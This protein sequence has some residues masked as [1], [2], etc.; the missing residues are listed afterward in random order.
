[1]RKNTGAQSRDRISQAGVKE[2]LADMMVFEPGQGRQ[3][4]FQQTR[5]E[6]CTDW[7]MRRPS[8]DFGN[9]RVRCLWGHDR[10]S[11]WKGRQG[12]DQMRN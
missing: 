7:A 10:K 5:K 11:G 2:S 9:I 3:M 8:K 12:L 4:E 6:T 1:M